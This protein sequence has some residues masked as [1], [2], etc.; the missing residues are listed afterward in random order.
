MQADCNKG[1]EKNN[2][3]MK[4]SAKKYR[5]LGLPFLQGIDTKRDERDRE[6]Q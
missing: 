4:I 3:L 1:F 2:L 6:S 5:P